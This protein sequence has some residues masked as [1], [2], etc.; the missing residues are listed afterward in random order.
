MTTEGGGGPER[1]AESH[2]DW[3]H[4]LTKLCDLMQ[5]H[6]SML[7][8]EREDC[9][10]DETDDSFERAVEEKVDEMWIGPVVVFYICLHSRSGSGPAYCLVSGTTTSLGE[11]GSIGRG[12]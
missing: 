3:N 10:D 5:E 9:W 7:K 12:S 1:F 2:K 4:R 11:L 8:G 6:Y